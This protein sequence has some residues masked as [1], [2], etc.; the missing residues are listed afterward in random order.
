MSNPDNYFKPGQSGNPNGRPKRDWTV[1]SLIEEAME[2]SDESGVPAKKII[3]QKLVSLAKR[4]DI[5]AV[6]EINQRL[7]GM[8]K[9]TTALEGS[10]EL[11][12]LVGLETT[13]E[14]ETN[15]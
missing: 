3:Y 6:K 15:Q 1:Q 12:G 4:G 14:K 11:K 5:Q 9:Q 7:D 2:E 10:V 8:P 13:N